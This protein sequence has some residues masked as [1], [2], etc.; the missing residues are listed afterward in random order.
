MT[1]AAQALAW[2]FVV[3][4]TVPDAGEFFLICSRSFFGGWCIRSINLGIPNSISKISWAREQPQRI[5]LH[6]QKEGVMNGQRS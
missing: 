4:E 1:R 2:T 6:N 3:P 5:S